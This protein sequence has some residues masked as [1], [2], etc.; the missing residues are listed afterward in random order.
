MV[1]IQTISRETMG[2]IQVWSSSISRVNPR[3]QDQTIFRLCVQG[4][5]LKQRSVVPPQK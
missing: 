2:K 3:L 1:Q 4:S 5:I